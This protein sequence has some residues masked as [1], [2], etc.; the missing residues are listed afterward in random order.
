MNS[1][2]RKNAGMTLSFR[3]DF[4]AFALLLVVCST[5][6]TALAA[7]RPNVVLVMLDDYGYECVGA[8]GGTSYQTPHL[9]KLAQGGARGLR[10]HVQP[11][12]T[13]TRVQLMTGQYNLRNYTQFGQLE[14]SQTTFAHL[15]QRAGYATCIAG[16]WQLG[17]DMKSPAHFGF[18]KYCLWQLDRRPTRYANAGLEIDGRHV[19]L[20]GG[21]YGPDVVSEYAR[22]FIASHKEHP[23]L[24]YY[25]MM[26]THGPFQPTPDSK[27]WDPTTADEQSQR[28]P[29]HF[30]DMVA[31]ADKLIGKLVIALEENGVRDNTLLIVL[32]DNGTARGITSRMGERVVH[33]GKASSTDAGTHVPL[34]ASWPGVIPAGL[35]LDDLI[36]STDFLPTICE[37]GR[38]EP[39]SS[40]TLDGRTFLPQLRGENGNPREW[41]YCWFTRYGG[42]KADF[43]FAMDKRYKLYRDGRLFDVEQDVEEKRPLDEQSRTGLAAESAQRLAQVFDKFK[44]ARPAAIAAQSTLGRR[45]NRAGND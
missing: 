44:D 16:K 39:P 17:R 37:A 12:C 6:G 15:F 3:V 34:I 21:K 38:V 28:D 31:Y 4:V 24:L 30:A 19:D 1:C 13:P 32:G 7:P 14:L 5:C 9:D 41:V 33:G 8:N 10:C 18:E 42:A 2:Q 23:F 36:D 35:V 11:L 25:P 40:L 29:A 43:E 26:L 20:T 45:E 22:E 27:D